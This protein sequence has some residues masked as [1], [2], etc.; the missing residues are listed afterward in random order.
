MLEP[1]GAVYRLPI[2]LF[3]HD[4]GRHSHANPI[5][6][7]V[8]AEVRGGLLWV[9]GV[10]RKIEDDGTEGGRMVKRRLDAAWADIK[11]RLVRGL[12]VEFLPITPKSP[13]AKRWTR[14][15]WQGLAVVPVPSNADAT[16]QLV[17]S[18][19]SSGAPQPGVPG[20]QTDNPR[21]PMKTI[22]EQIQEHE[23]TRAAK[24]ARQEALNTA[25]AERGETMNETEGQEFDDLGAEVRSI[26]AHLVR[27]GDLK[28]QAETRATA[29]PTKPGAA[30]AAQARSGVPV[31]QVRTAA[32]PGIGMARYVMA[33][34]RSNG[35]RYEAAE[36]ARAVWG[37]SAEDVVAQL[38]LMSRGAIA[39]GDTVTSGW[40][41]Q[42]VPVTT[43][44]NE[45]LELLRPAT[46]I[47]RIPGLRRVPFNIAIPSQTGGGTYKWVGQGK[48]KPL[49]KPT[50]SSVTLDMAKAS[51]IIVL[52]EELVRSSTPSAQVIVRDELVNGITQFL[53]AQFVDPDKAIDAGVSPASITNG[54]AGITASGTGEAELRADLIQ[55]L[56]SFS[57]N[58]FSLGGIVL[59]VSETTALAISMLTNALGQ[60]AFPGLTVGG[61]SLEGIPVVVSNAVS[62]Q[63]VAVHA[64]S[65]L[66]ADDGPVEID[67]SREASLEMDDTPT[68]PTAAGTVLVSLWQR[69][70]I[71]LRGERFINWKKARTGAVNR[72]TDVS[73]GVPES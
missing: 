40:A 47:G 27:L 58:N 39:A 31:V 13:H 48:A 71:A 52:T 67:V 10:V 3:F 57:T 61:G 7:I 24:V 32:E 38:K 28:R 41:S 64:S 1:S 54:V 19:A 12:S 66:V 45:F 21:R 11:N 70:L 33:L 35:N 65:V 37:D 68:E 42:L 16:I 69:N 2:P 63:I 30:P 6:E 8:A 50:L 14:W 43:L 4:A 62:D 23:N 60:K 29:V 59:L 15:S 9:R 73:Y 55:L 17:R 72:I 46:L 22:A 18:I 53:D 26:D 44:S 49:T 56:Q 34:A 36:Y 5:G 51:G 25:A 20:S